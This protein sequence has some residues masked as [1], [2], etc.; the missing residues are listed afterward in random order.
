MPANVPLYPPDFR[1]ALIAQAG[2]KRRKNP[3]TVR[4]ANVAWLLGSRAGLSDLNARCSKSI[5][6][7]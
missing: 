7:L 1:T 2:R 3:R 5:L 4:P 6:S